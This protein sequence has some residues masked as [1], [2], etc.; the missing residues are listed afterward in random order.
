MSYPAHLIDALAR[1][2]AK[3]A[4]DRLIKDEMALQAE[5][6]G[7][8]QRAADIPPPHY[9]EKAGTAAG[10]ARVE[11]SDNREPLLPESRP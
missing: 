7:R 4:L 11:S 6:Q 3:V 2:Y 9:P 8:T 5:L 1:V 10:P